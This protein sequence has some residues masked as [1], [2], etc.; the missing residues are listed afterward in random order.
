MSYT[1]S[2]LPIELKKMCLMILIVLSIGM[3]LGIY[4]IKLNS[5]FKPKSVI[6]HYNGSELSSEDEFGISYAKNMKE[7]TLTVHT[8]V[9][10]FTFIFSI[11]GFIFYGVESISKKLKQ[12]LLIEPLISTL[13]TFGSMYLIRFVHSDF[14]Y[15]M[16]FSS[17][18]L[19]VSFFTMIIFSIRELFFVTQKG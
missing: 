10:S 12:F 1:L 14:V 4:F 19:Y 16:I 3:C 15:L 11:L 13:S 8:H 9:M 2:E 6:A 7:I 18:L 17:T 5:S